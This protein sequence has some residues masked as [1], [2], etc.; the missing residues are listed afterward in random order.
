[1]Q[2]GL[3]RYSTILAPEWAHSA[4]LRDGTQKGSAGTVA[5]LS[6]IAVRNAAPTSHPRNSGARIARPRVDLMEALMEDFDPEE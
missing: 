1:M 5:R 2:E 6:R 4:A 3:R